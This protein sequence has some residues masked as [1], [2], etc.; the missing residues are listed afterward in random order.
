MS[1]DNDEM[2]SNLMDFICQQSLWS[3]FVKF[4]EKKGYTEEELDDF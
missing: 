4:M 2:V 1:I 3:E